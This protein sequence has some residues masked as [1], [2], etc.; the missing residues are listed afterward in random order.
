MR[1]ILSGWLCLMAFPLLFG[2]ADK[3]SLTATKTEINIKIDGILDEAV[4]D[5]TDRAEGFVT[6]RPEPGLPASQATSVSV[7]YSDQGLYVGARLYDTAPDSILNE[8]TDRDNLGNTDFFGIIVDP[9][10]S[11]FNGFEF[12]TTPGEVQFDAKAVPNGEDTNWDAVWSTKSTITQDGWV[13]EMFIPFSALRFPKTA[14]QEWD[15]NFVRMIRRTGEQSFWSEIKPEIDGFMNQAGKLTNIRDIKAP[16]RLQLTPFATA[17][18]AMSN[19]PGEVDPKSFGNSFGGGMDLKLGLSDAF[20]LDMTLI[21]DFSEARSDDNILNLGPFEQRFDEQRA[22]FTE[23]TELFN[24]GGFFYSRRVG[25]SLF[26]LG[27]AYDDLADDEEVASVPGKAQ[28]VNATKISGRTSNGTGIGFFNAIEKRSF[29][30]ITNDKG[31]SREVLVNPR[32]NYN[33]LVVD[34]N[35]PNNSSVTLINT[36]VMR[37]GNSTDANVTGLVYDIHNKQ[38]KYSVRGKFG[39]SQRFTEGNNETGHVANVRIQKISGNLQWH[40]GYN[41]ESDTYNPNDLGILFNNNERS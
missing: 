8:L 31:E 16:F 32:T 15:L 18:G 11:G 12:L 22:F 10:Q 29:A 41:E 7:I 1:T 39:Y 24:K 27:D 20:T 3:K 6:R 34:Q 40:L 17:A 28:L 21:P 26:R 33:V 14:I 4:W 30:T 5:D 19:T 37:E 2:Q 9:Y 23:G 36:N 35:L 38:N 13:V 25:G